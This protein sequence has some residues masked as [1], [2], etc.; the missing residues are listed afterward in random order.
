MFSTF[1][2]LSSLF[3]ALGQRGRSKKRVGEEQDQPRIGLSAQ[4]ERAI[5]F[6]NKCLAL[7]F[8]GVSRLIEETEGPV[9]GVTKNAFF[10]NVNQMFTGSSQLPTTAERAVMKSLCTVETTKQC[11]AAGKTRRR[12][13]WRQ[14]KTYLS[15]DLWILESACYWKAQ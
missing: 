13:D 15:V 5:H 11:S 9:I 1:S 4:L 7:R 6:Q 3:Q 2:L 14:R 10:A 8:S 12:F